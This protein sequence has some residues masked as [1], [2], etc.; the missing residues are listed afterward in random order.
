MLRGACLRDLLRGASQSCV[1]RALTNKMSSVTVLYNG[2]REAIQLS[3]SHMPVH[4]IVRAACARFGLAGDARMMLVHPRT[5]KQGL[6]PALP[7]MHTGLSNNVN[8]ELVADR[9]PGATAG[10]DEERD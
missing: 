1:R 5:H 2:R 9:R 6:D 4:E 10:D 3:S 7:F 8:L